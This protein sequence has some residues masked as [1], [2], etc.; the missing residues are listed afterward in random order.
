MND[1][2][3]YVYLINFL[4]KIR[5]SIDGFNSPVIVNFNDIDTGLIKDKGK[6][7][8]MLN[9]FKTDKVP[10][11]YTQ[12]TVIEDYEIDKENNDIIIIY[13]S[14]IK[15]LKLYTEMIM[16]NEINLTNRHITP[17]LLPPETKWES[18]TIKFKDGHDVDILVPGRNEVIRSSYTEMGF[19]DLK[20]RRPNFQW[21][22]LIGLANNDRKMSW[23]DPDANDN[24]KKQKQLLSEKLR[25]YFTLTED[26]FYLYR[27][28]KMYEIKL[29]LLSESEQYEETVEK[30]DDKL[31]IK[32]YL[33]QNAPSV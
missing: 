26:P 24:I 15:K 22:L 25:R 4:I 5:N 33:D 7:F 8:E 13:D 21:R 6:L 14:S 19:Q 20:K 12:E 11:N 9:Y 2:G 32:E 10:V 23:D 27:K 28:E 16:D 30:T 1:K 31:D 29:N 3:R 17:L 18:I